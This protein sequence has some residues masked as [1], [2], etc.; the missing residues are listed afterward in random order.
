MKKSATKKIKINKTLTK[1]N[2]VSKTL[3]DIIKESE[4][5]VLLDDTQNINESS[6]ADAMSTGLSNIGKDILNV[7]KVLGKSFKKLFKIYISYPKDLF[8]ALVRGESL[9]AVHLKHSE[10]Q[11]NLTGE[12]NTLVNG[13]SG[14]KDLNNFI[15]LAAPHAKVMDLVMSKGGSIEKKAENLSTSARKTFNVGI[16]KIYSASGE[17]PPKWLLV[18]TGDTEYQEYQAQIYFHDT[19]L[20]I[21]KLFDPKIKIK[22]FDFTSDE[23]KKKMNLE[24]ELNVG[25]KKMQ[26]VFRAVSSNK[27]NKAILSAFIEKK[28]P[29]KTRSIKDKIDIKYLGLESDEVKAFT[30]L[31]FN[32][33]VNLRD[34]YVELYKDS[35]KSKIT[36]IPNTLHVE[37]NRLKNELEN[38]KVENTKITIDGKNYEISGFF[39][40]KPGS[41]EKSEDNEVE[42]S[43]KAKE[44]T[45]KESNESFSKKIKFVN[46]KLLKEEEEKTE[47]TNIFSEIT[48]EVAAIINAVCFVDVYV[49]LK[50]QTARLTTSSF[51]IKG[52]QELI[53]LH[54]KIVDNEK[55]DPSDFNYT[56]SNISKELKTLTDTISSIENLIESVPYEDIEEY[57]PKFKGSKSEYS[58][59]VAE[60]KKYANEINDKL[61]TTFSECEKNA[62]DTINAQ[63]AEGAPDISSEDEEKVK[64]LNFA[65]SF[66]ESVGEIDGSV[67]QNEASEYLST[68]KSTNI[69][70]II[71]NFETDLK[72]SYDNISLPIVTK[73]ISVKKVEDV[74]AISK[75]LEDYAQSNKTDFGDKIKEISKK[76]ADKLNI[77]IETTQEESEETT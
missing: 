43:E 30:K 51:Y 32:E 68:L 73:S 9:R 37:L 3:Q 35:G 4:I 25:Y 72:D 65:Q 20:K 19:M 7:G 21:T 74:K 70:E 67:I 76:I 26:D 14:A 17:T 23:K 66:I 54:E 52:F 59:L 12:I 41:T 5:E 56:S 69:K 60:E 13:M 18:D 6:I 53:N 58:E 49:L 36:Q 50:I 42:S 40:S 27:N 33:K 44:V 24:R 28:L 2:N 8:L 71:N 55:I 63:S 62:N 39:G 16:R 22:S 47:D 31:V 1:Q 15:T 64:S 57:F 48:G 75:S 61:K 10:I 29:I 11:R 46:G 38:N 77:E 34:V 45:D